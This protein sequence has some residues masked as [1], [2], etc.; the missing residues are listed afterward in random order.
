MAALRL[1]AAALIAAAATLGHFGSCGHTIAG[2]EAAIR[3]AVTIDDAGAAQ[4]EVGAIV[5]V[6]DCADVEIVTQLAT[7]TGTVSARF[8][9]TTTLQ[10]LRCD[11]PCAPSWTVE[12]RGAP[13]ATVDVD[14]SYR[15]QCTDCDATRFTI[16]PS[17]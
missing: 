5:E 17:R 11:G 1:R 15:A 2:A 12:V 10:A 6:D 4:I 3:H 8:E 16:Y 14:V 13:G 9:D 7:R